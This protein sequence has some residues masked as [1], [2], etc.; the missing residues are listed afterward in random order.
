MSI[1]HNTDQ[2]YTNSEGEDKLLS[3][4]YY[5]HSAKK[6]DW[7]AGI[8]FEPEEIEI[9]D[10]KTQDGRNPE[11][12]FE[13]WNEEWAQEVYAMRILADWRVC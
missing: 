5:H 1:L 4:S 8:P 2:I 13:D 9:V 7:E 12:V 6:G 11:R 3:I 10:I